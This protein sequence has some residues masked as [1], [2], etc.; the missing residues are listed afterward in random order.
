[1]SAP[2]P[3]LPL[4]F[5]L[6]ATPPAIAQPSTEEWDPGG[7]RHV[8]LTADSAEQVPPVPIG[9][10]R[11]TTFVFHAPLLPGSV[12]VEGREFFSSVTVD[13]GAGVVNVLPSGALP[14]GRELMLTARFADG[15]LPEWARLRLVVSATRAERQV[16]VYRRPR[17]AESYRQAEQQERERAERCEARLVQVEAQGQYAGGFMGLFDA[18]LLGEGKGIAVKPLT[19]DITQR[20]GETLRV[21]SAWSYRAEKANTVAVELRLENKS[22]QSWTVEGVEGAELVSAEGERLRVLRVHLP[23]PL[24]PGSEGRLVVE[25]EATKA[26][27]RGTFLLKLGE[28]GGPRTITVRNVTFP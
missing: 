9:P 24:L 14:P 15:A 6:L 11:A 4:L 22:K 21:Q 17:S 8:E 7:E 23:T 1:M 3:A 25:A 27:S 12:V 2:L 20:P 26:Q 19:Q 5:A 28:A 18:G 13:E 16:E 10:N